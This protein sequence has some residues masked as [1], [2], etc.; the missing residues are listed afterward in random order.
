MA[1]TH[2]VLTDWH[3]WLSFLGLSVAICFSPGAGAVQ[4]M[5]MGAAYGLVR[6]YWSILGLELGLLAQLALI[7]A[8]VGAVVAESVL[9]FNAI[10]WVGVAYLIY[11]AVRQW[12]ATGYAQRQQDAQGDGRLSLVARGF[13]VNATN[14]KA[15]VFMLAVMPQFL[16]PTASLLPQYGILGLTFITVDVVVMSIYTGLSARFLRW[17]RTPRQ[18]TILNRILSALFAVAAVA[19]SAVRAVA[20]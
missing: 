2:T 5:A 18:Q 10:K 12:G 4:S 8:G 16:L 19:L 1:M 3:L 9:V 17:L 11:L 6:G 15:L 20:A 7:A 14:P 13:V